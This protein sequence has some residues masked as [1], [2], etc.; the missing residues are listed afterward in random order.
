[1]DTTCI[2]FAKRNWATFRS[3]GARLGSTC[4]ITYKHPLM[5][6]AYHTFGNMKIFFRYEIKYMKI[7]FD[8]P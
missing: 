1:M 6:K 7:L 4:L 3:L 8:F 2:G 5:G